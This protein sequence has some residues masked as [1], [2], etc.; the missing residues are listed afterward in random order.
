MIEDGARE[1]R[2]L[3]IDDGLV[4]WADG[5]SV[6]AADALRIEQRMRHDLVGEHIRPLDPEGAE[7]REFLAAR[8][9][10]PQGEATRQKSGHLALGKATE[11]GRALEARDLACVLGAP[12]AVEHETAGEIEVGLRRR[13]E[14][15]ELEARGI[16]GEAA[17]RAVLDRVDR[18]GVLVDEA[19]MQ[20][21]DDKSPSFGV[22]DTILP[23]DMDRL[24]LLESEVAEA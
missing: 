17:D 10:R 16:I 13:R 15:A 12:V 19:A 23:M 9:R 18:H 8:V 6:G 21:L 24:I 11:E 3:D 1:E 7:K 20:R 4:T 22:P 2:A 5:E 14:P